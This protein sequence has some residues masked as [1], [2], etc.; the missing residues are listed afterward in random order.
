VRRDVR[1]VG[2]TAGMSIEVTAG[3]YGKK[4]SVIWTI[5][6]FKSAAT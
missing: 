4:I 2:A 6:H 3:S 5:E 1:L